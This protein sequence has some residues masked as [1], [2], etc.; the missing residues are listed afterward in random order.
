VIV[1]AIVRTAEEILHVGAA[2]L[3][4]LISFGMPAAEAIPGVGVEVPVANAI[5]MA[6]GVG[7]RR[8]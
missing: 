8:T 2:V 5:L 3:D 7:Y 1:S 4:G 6:A